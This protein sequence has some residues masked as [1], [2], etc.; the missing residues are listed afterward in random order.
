MPVFYF[1]F[2]L[3]IYFVDKLII[4][5]NEMIYHWD[6]NVVFDKFILLKT[7]LCVL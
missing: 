6:L 4:I 7:L 5:K 1:V 3:F 2:Y